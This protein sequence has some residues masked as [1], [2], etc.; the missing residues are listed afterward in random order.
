[1]NPR[2]TSET[3]LKGASGGRQGAPKRKREPRL[4]ERFREE[5]R[6]ALLAAAEQTL[7]RDGLAN[8][9]METIA[10]AA[11]VAVGTVY[12]YFSDREQLI[13]ALLELRR[14]EL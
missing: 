14:S 3:E 1:M 5:T 6:R 10:Q 9:R 8:A 11:G 7:A 4:R 2:S 12:N 13:S